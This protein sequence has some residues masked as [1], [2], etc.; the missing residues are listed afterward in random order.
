MQLR[1]KS[2]SLGIKT[3]SKDEKQF[4]VKQYISNKTEP[5]EEIARN[6]KL[7]NITDQEVILLE[8][9][10]QTDD[11]KPINN[12]TN[13]EFDLVEE[14]KEKWYQCTECDFESKRFKA[15]KDCKSKK[16]Q[17]ISIFRKKEDWTWDTVAQKIMSE[18]SF[19][20][21][22]KTDE[23]LT[24]DGRRYSQKVAET[25]IRSR[26]D[27][28]EPTQSKSFKNEVIDKIKTRTYKDFEIF[29][30]RP[31]I[32]TL[33]NGILDLNQM[34][35]SEH[36]P[37]NLTTLLLPLEYKK[38][39]FEIKEETIFEDIE[40][41]L[42]DTLFWKFLKSSFTLDENFE[43]KSFEAALEIIASVFVKQ[44]IDAKAVINLGKGENGK[45]VFLSYI[46][47]LVGNENK[48][49]I[50]LQQLSEDKFLP[51]QLK[52]KLV[53][54]F[55]DLENNELRKAGL[56][57]AIITNEGITGQEKHGRP[58]TFNP[59]CKLIFSCNRFPK[60]FDQSQG[61]FRRWII[62]HWNRNFENDPQRDEHLLQKLVSNKEEK[63][64]VFSTLIHLSRQ[65]Y[66]RGKFSHSKDW[67]TIQ[68]EWNANAD[69][70]SD[71]VEHY[72]KDSD[73]NTRV[74]E[75]HAWYKEIM[76]QKGENPLGI[77]QFGKIFREYYD[78]SVNHDVRIWLGVE[79]KK[80]IQEKMKEFDE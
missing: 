39:Q 52:D 36:T 8:K 25:Y 65:L 58:F 18:K 66:Q 22:T 49:N 16:H 76:Y 29:N 60:V 26:T 64:K 45:S 59:F 3:G 78:Q 57:K 14:P 15:F 56:I 74:R 48:S 24:F 9:Q 72:T 77:G 55:A 1:K 46:E 19:V 30:S 33:E 70:I 63:N 37:D 53:N 10:N 17:V 12:N 44:Q 7:E 4:I 21:L 34:K 38:P 51:S 43:K 75:M 31:D 54:I 47:S 5:F 73:S 61:F 50:Q 35:L 40:K 62:L 71:F 11:S 23:I 68:K 27:Q 20:T 32:L 13:N 41:N 79:P 67:K 69:P 2:Q 42:K 28:L 80:P 6:V